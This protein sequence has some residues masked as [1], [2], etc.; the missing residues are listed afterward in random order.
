M[1]AI[2][3]LTEAE[4]VLTVVFVYLVAFFEQRLTSRARV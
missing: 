3:H 2:S 1:N 4:T